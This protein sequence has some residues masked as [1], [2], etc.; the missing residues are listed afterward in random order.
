VARIE[1][2]Y[3][4][5]KNSAAQK[6]L[7]MFTRR[8]V[9]TYEKLEQSTIRF[10]GVELTISRCDDCSQEVKWLTPYQT[11]AISGLTLR[12]IF[13]LIEANHIHFTETRVGLLLICYQSI[14]RICGE[15]I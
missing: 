5:I 1:A 7:S 8:T 11:L 12:E 4:K 13:R 2:L 10:S 14:T 6:D 3:S 15:K 9:I